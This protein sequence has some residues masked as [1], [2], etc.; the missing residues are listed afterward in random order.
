[1]TA[2]DERADVLVIGSGA[3]GAIASLVLARAGL[4]VVCLEQGGWV[5]PKD[6]PHYS[7]DWQWQRRTRWN[8]DLN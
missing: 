8:P 1:M 4:R 5:E 6:H 3:S 7:A 2:R